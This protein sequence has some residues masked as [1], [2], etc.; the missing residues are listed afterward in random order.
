[1]RFALLFVFAGALSTLCLTAGC[2]EDSSRST[3]KEGYNLLRPNRSN[4]QPRREIQRPPSSERMEQLA[5]ALRDD[6]SPSAGKTSRNFLYYGAFLLGVVLIGVVLAYWQLLRRNR[7][8]WELNDPMALLKELNH[9]HQLSDSEK[10]FMRE[11]SD[12]NA[13]PSPL[14][15]FVEP[16]FLL[17]ALEN[18]VYFSARSSVQQLLAKLFDMTPEEDNL[19]AVLT[20]SAA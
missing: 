6:F 8:E 3:K 4:T 15:L 10:R 19:T 9:V 1:M 12:K 17:D 13:L 14:T 20:E 5:Q 18:D 2:R 16:K 11:L 7:A